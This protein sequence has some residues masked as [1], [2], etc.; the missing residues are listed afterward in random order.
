[1]P[2]H[3]YYIHYPVL[4]QEGQ[5]EVTPVD[6][7]E[8]WMAGTPKRPSSKPP[9]PPSP[10]SRLSFSGCTS[11]R[12]PKESAKYSLVRDPDSDTARFGK[13]LFTVAI[14]FKII[15]PNNLL[16]CTLWTFQIYPV[17]CF[18]YTTGKMYLKP[19]RV[20][21]YGT[22][23]IFMSTSVRKKNNVDLGHFWRKNTQ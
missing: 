22:I 14:Y 7:L 19:E 1:M 23:F 15:P 16:L 12:V 8:H 3:I 4:G 21:K 10:E 2:G 13:T 9:W 17:K 20:N 5:L 18:V 6:T 11:S